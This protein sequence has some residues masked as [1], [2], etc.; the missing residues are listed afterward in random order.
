MRLD[1]IRSKDDADLRLLLGRARRELFDLR[2]KSVMGEVESP[3]AFREK[4]RSIA[5]I[6]TVLNERRHG[7]RGA[8]PH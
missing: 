4:R 8:R 7:V 3:D 1:E 6:L 2:F 5:K